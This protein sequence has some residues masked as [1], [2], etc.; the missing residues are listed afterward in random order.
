M[1]EAF[2]ITNGEQDCAPA[3]EMEDGPL[4]GHDGPA[5]EHPLR[6]WVCDNTK[7]APGRVE[8][9]ISVYRKAQDEQGPDR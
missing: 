5:K 3:L 9:W 7:H 6:I 4:G 2:H 8:A 1:E